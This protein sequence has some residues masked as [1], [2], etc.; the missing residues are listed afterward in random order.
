MAAETFN[1]EKREEST[2]RVN[3]IEHKYHFDWSIF[4]RFQSFLLLL[5]FLIWY[6]F[7]SDLSLFLSLSYFIYLLFASLLNS[8]IPT[9]CSSQ[10]F[11]HP[12]QFMITKAS[13]SVVTGFI[14]NAIQKIR[15]NHFNVMMI[16]WDYL[17]RR[18]A[19]SN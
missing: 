14:W 6:A 13:K 2:S 5:P 10:C 3:N 7:C 19:C 17:I 18:I 4:F 11:I 15:K 9:N 16:T 1:D 8:I 12:I